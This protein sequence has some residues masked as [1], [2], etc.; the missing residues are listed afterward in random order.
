MPC[1]LFQKRVSPALHLTVFRGRQQQ[2]IGL[3]PVLRRIPV[4]VGLVQIGLAAG[5]V[6]FTLRTVTS[7]SDKTVTLPAFQKVP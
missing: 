4:G 1:R 5:L 3:L 2:E 6:I 7:E